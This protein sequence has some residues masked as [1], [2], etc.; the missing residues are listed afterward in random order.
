MYMDA[1]VVQRPGPALGQGVPEWQLG[2]AVQSKDEVQV[3]YHWD[4]VR[5]CEGGGL[6]KSALR[7]A[8]RRML[9]LSWP[10]ANTLI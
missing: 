10:K 8:V 6:G 4:E 7:K 2:R 5:R 9:A 1:S 3:A